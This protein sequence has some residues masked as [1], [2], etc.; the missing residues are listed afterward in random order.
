MSAQ[1]QT[2][3]PVTSVYSASQTMPER[4]A[5]YLP[6]VPM[7]ALA[8]V[9]LAAAIVA[10]WQGGIHHAAALAWVGAILIAA[11]ILVWRGLVPVAPGRAQVI[12]LFGRYQGTIREQGMQWVNP[13]TNRIAVS[14][15]IR[16]M[17]SAV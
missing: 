14:T 1:V 3:E 17:E 2:A 7:L 15:R 12:Q 9:L 13:F 6:G 8:V 16:N 5:R 4:K 11:D 10:F